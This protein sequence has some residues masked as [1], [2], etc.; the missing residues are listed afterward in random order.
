MSDIVLKHLNMN[1]GL[2]IQTVSGAIIT[3]V[4]NRV[5]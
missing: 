2:Q 1:G 3:C 5:L 4:V